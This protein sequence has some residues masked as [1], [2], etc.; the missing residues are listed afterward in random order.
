MGIGLCTPAS[1]VYVKERCNGFPRRLG[2]HLKGKVPRDLEHGH[3][4]LLVYVQYPERAIT[5]TWAARE[6]TL[7]WGQGYDGNLRCAGGFLIP[8]ES[9]WFS[10]T[11]SLTEC[12]SLLLACANNRTIT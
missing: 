9:L 1:S 2:W 12:H 3:T 4:I 11:V 8:I 6:C 7:Y 5:Y 10:L